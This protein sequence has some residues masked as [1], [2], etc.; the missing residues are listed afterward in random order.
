MAKPGATSSQSTKHGLGIQKG[1]GGS[2]GARDDTNNTGYIIK[3]GR[4]IMIKYDKMGVQATYLQLFNV[5]NDS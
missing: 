2:R 3:A 4:F 5:T 1:V